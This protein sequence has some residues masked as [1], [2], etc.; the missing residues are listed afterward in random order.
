MDKPKAPTSTMLLKKLSEKIVAHIKRKEHS[1]PNDVPLLE[2]EIHVIQ[3]L[4]GYIVRKFTLKCKNNNQLLNSLVKKVDESQPLINT[5]NRG[6]L[7]SVK[8][9]LV[10]FCCCC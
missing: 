10:D 7:T 5:L 8:A 4:A 3:Y 6:G 1:N 9:E 2:K